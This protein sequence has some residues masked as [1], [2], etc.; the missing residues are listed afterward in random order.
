VDVISGDA[1]PELLMPTEILERL[2]RVVYVAPPK[3]AKVYRA[4]YDTRRANLGLPG[5]LWERLHP[6]AM[7]W[8]RARDDA[9]SSPRFERRDARM[10]SC[11]ELA[12]A[13]AMAKSEFGEEPFQRLLY[14]VVAPG[15]TLS[16]TDAETPE[17]LR[18]REE[19]CK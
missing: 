9:R 19:G 8:V 14:E 11:R 15:M 3:V 2:L 17:A 16:T 4:S 5:D 7:P 10:R 18:K 1:N 13:L 6:I 12:L